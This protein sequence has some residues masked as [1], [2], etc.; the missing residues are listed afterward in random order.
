MQLLQKTYNR[1]AHASIYSD[2]TTGLVCLYL[3]AKSSLL[4]IAQHPLP[5]VSGCGTWLQIMFNNNTPIP[6]G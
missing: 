6:H 3:F 5:I 1:F 4:S 2:F